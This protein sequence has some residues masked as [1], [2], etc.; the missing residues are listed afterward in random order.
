MLRDHTYDKMKVLVE[1]SATCNFLKKHALPELEDGHEPLT[2]EL[3]KE[4]VEDLDKHVDKLR[5]AV[6]GLAKEGKLH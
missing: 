4:I 5:M 3:Y 2:Q 1:L 6:E